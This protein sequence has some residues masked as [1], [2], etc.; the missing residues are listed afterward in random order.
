MASKRKTFL[1][2]LIAL[3][4]LIG[5]GVYYV[6][7]NLNSIVATLIEEQG[8]IATQTQVKVGGVDIRLSEAT[9]S[10]RMNRMNCSKLAPPR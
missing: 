5:G 8:S 2:V 9:A 1:Y 4:V 6:L 10:S 3:L 7:S